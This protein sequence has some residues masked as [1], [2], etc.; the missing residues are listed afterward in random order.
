MSKKKK[1]VYSLQL[2][3]SGNIGTHLVSVPWMLKVWGNQ[4]QDH[5][6]VL[7][8]W[9]KKYLKT[10]MLLYCCHLRTLP[11]STFCVVKSFQCHALWRNLPI[12]LHKN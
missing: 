6:S 12:M 3:I 5:M 7:A 8:D 4:P 11:F 9:M 1:V 10:Q 2:L